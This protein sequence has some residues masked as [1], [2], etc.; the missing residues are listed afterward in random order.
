M[1]HKDT[2][3]DRLKKITQQEV[4]WENRSRFMLWDL[5]KTLTKGDINFSRFIF[6]QFSCD[7][8]WILR[9]FPLDDA[10]EKVSSFYRWK[11][12]IRITQ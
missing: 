12:S 1:N 9:V 2:S 6:I 8:Y 11:I 5:P 10:C 3:K 4:T 7:L